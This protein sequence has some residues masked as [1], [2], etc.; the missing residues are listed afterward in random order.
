MET[1][2]NLILHL[3]V[4]TVDGLIQSHGTWLYA[5]LFA[6]IFCET[7]LV[8]TPFLPG[9]SLLF[10][11]GA[12][13][14]KLSRDTSAPTLSVHTL[15]VLLSIA[16]IV[17]DNVNY[18]IGAYVGPRAFSGKIRFLKKEYLDRTHQ[19]F[20]KYGPK[21]IVLARFVPIVRTFTP[22]VAGAARMNYAK[23]LAYDIPGGI[24]WV[25][26]FVYLGAWFSNIAFVRDHFELVV[27]AIIV[28]SVLPIVVEYL[29]ARH[30]GKKAAGNTTDAPQEVESSDVNP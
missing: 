27:P 16:A 17:G 23:F 7:G 11:F 8:V 21:A 18:W 12:E 10:L 5:I 25:G 26:I 29:R 13:I 30:R 2:K 1:L 3:N 4:E 6:V 15:F 22:F 28:I 20:E 14:A 9:D 24:A 19:F